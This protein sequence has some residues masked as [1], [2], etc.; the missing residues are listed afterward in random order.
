MLTDC[1]G[2]HFC[3][4]CL[5]NWFETSLAQKRNKSC[6]HCRNEKFQYMIDLP[7]KRKIDDFEIY[8]PNHRQGCDT[9][10]I[11][12]NL[13]E[14]LRTCAYVTVECTNNC[15]ALLLR[16]NL[17]EHCHQN[18]LRRMIEC[19][20]CGMTSTYIEIKTTH[21]NTSKCPDVHF[22]LT[23]DHD[24]VNHRLDFSW[25]SN[26]SLRTPSF[27]FNPGYKVHIRCETTVQENIEQTARLLTKMADGS[28]SLVLERG[29]RDDTLTWPI[30][31]KI[32]IRLEQL[33][34]FD[35]T[36]NSYKSTPIHFYQ[37]LCN[38][39][40]PS[41]NLTRVDIGMERV[42]RTEKIFGHPNFTDQICNGFH[43]I[44]TLT[45]HTCS[46]GDDEDDNGSN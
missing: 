15:G 6:P 40:N 18:C 4:A 20:N 9:T 42:I 13:Q 14:H 12:Q 39:C 17:H 8:C 5:G 26:S 28:F 23:E 41:T 19:E 45:K 22:D 33:H 27:Y 1:C 37:I 10:F 2:Q 3:K 43:A 29:E 30:P 21:M 25:E 35:E 7:M 34:A 16:I 46:R 38:E 44:I 32:E 31:D 11:L 36:E 24:T